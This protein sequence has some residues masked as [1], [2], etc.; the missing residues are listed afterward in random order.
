MEAIHA[1]FEIMPPI[2]FFSSSPNVLHPSDEKYRRKSGYQGDIV[3]TGGARG[4]Y[5][6]RVRAFDRGGKKSD[7]LVEAIIRRCVSSARRIR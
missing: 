4:L 6:S 2:I 3:E 5:L 1:K 7:T